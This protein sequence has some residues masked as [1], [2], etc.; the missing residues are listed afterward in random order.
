[1]I[2]HYKHF[3]SK[4]ILTCFLLPVT[5]MSYPN[6]TG[7]QNPLIAPEF[8]YYYFTGEEDYLHLTFMNRNEG[9]STEIYHSLSSDSGYQL[10]ATVAPG[11]TTFDHMNLKPRTTH[12]YK[13][14]ARLGDQVSE[15]S[16]VFYMTTYSKN[17]PPILTARA[18]NANTIELSLTD[19]SYNDIAYTI[20]TFT[21]ATEYER[22]ND[23]YGELYFEA[24]SGQTKTILH[25]PA[26]AGKTYYYGVE[27]VPHHD[28]STAMVTRASFTMPV[29][30]CDDTQSV[31][32][33]VWT[34]VPGGKVSSIPVYFTPNQVTTL[35]SLQGPLNAGDNFGARVR[36]YLCAPQTGNYTFWIASDDQSEL[37]LSTDATVANKKLIASVTGYTSAGQWE[38]YT[39]QKS[40]PISLQAG[41]TY[42]F[43]ILHK[44]SASGDHFAVGWQLP[45]GTLERPIGGN[46]LIRFGRPNEQ[47][48]VT[49]T[50]PDH[51]TTL[52]APATV[53][54]SANAFDPETSITKVDFFLNNNLVGS[55]ATAPFSIQATNLPA[56]NYMMK[57]LAY[58]ADGQQGY[59]LR[60]FDVQSQPCAGT[61][62]VQRE[63]WRNISGTYVSSIPVNTPPTSSEPLTSLQT[64]QYRYDNYGSRIRG[65]IC[66]PLTGDYQLWI[67]AD[68]ASQF[69]LSTD[70]SPANKRMLA[71]TTSATKFKEYSKN[72]TQFS[73]TFK[74]QAGQKYYFEILHKEAT[75]NDFVT[76]RWQMPNSAVEDPIPGSRLIPFGAIAENKLPV[77]DIT[78][79]AD[80]ATLAQGS[81]ITVR[82]TAS[83]ADGSIASVRFEANGSL[84]VED[85]TAPYEYA[86]TNVPSGDYRITARA[87]DDRGA[88]TTDEIYISVRT[89]VACT[90]SGQLYRELW[91]NIPGTSISSIPTGTEPDQVTVLTSFSTPNYT[92]NYYGSRIR[93]YL[94]APSSGAYTF[95]ISSDDNSELY[96]STDDNPANKIRIAYLNGAVRPGVYSQ[97]ST[98]VSAPI[99]LQAGR[100]YYIEVLHKEGSGA[101]FVSVGWKLPDGTFQAPIPGNRLSPFEDLSTSAAAMLVESEL[102]LEALELSVYPNPVKRGEN[103]SITFDQLETDSETSFQLLSPVGVT[104]QSTLVKSGN[105]ALEVTISDKLSPGFYFATVMSG[106]KRWV[107][108]LMVE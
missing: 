75:G 85:V 91:M 14:K 52:T 96:L 63:I 22:S 41:T 72:H 67:S 44:E 62:T 107:K 16:D 74:L 23:F 79:P 94:C 29:P 8:E 70:E 56:A 59:D 60:T 18:V 11:V 81:T 26:E 2:L 78:N 90:G 92:S 37:W 69:W 24:D 39:T 64:A 28:Q 27:L 104:V 31:E 86:W 12:Y 15:F 65:Y 46:R 83:D 48:I 89:M 95:N 68:D 19:K 7:D 98:Q 32:R 25:F 77:V 93:G 47:P 71:S 50:A 61:G 57:A 10:I 100:T 103:I 84:L 45:N 40:V 43:E 105:G 34:N 80:R 3:Y 53:T 17:Y 35:T 97:Y 51:R 102:G 87:K 101:D 1:M 76:V 13:L 82:A 108:K 106:R 99:T 38:K 21:S 33:E 42:Y 4:I 54:L 36:G 30:E 5:F 20:Y 58:S 55:D 6:G 49:I 9:A 66:A 88:T 73:G